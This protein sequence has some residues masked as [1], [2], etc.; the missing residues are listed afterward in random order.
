MDQ[1]VSTTMYSHPTNNYIDDPSIKLSSTDESSPRCVAAVPSMTSNSKPQCFDEEPF[2]CAVIVKQ[3]SGSETT[4]EKTGVNPTDP[5]QSIPLQSPRRIALPKSPSSRSNSKNNPS[6]KQKASSF[7][8][9]R[10]QLTQQRKWKKEYIERT[11]QSKSRGRSTVS[12]DEYS[13]GSRSKNSVP[14]SALGKELLIEHE[15]GLEISIANHLQRTGYKS[16]LIPTVVRYDLPNSSHKSYDQENDYIDDCSTALDTVSSLN[17]S[18]YA[19]D[20][21]LSKCNS[22]ASVSGK[23][24]KAPKVIQHTVHPPL[25]VS[26]VKKKKKMTKKS[27]KSNFFADDMEA[28]S[29][30]SDRQ[31]YEDAQ[32]VSDVNVLNE[33][34]I[35]RKLLGDVSGYTPGNIVNDLDTT[36]LISNTEKP[37]SHQ[38]KEKDINKENDIPYITPKY[39][40]IETRK[41]ALREVSRER[42]IKS[43]MLNSAEQAT[44]NNLPYAG[45]S[46][47]SDNNSPNTLRRRRLQSS[48]FTSDDDN[49][50]NNQNN[51]K[52]FP[53]EELNEFPS[54]PQIDIE[55]SDDT[56]AN[57]QSDAMSIKSTRSAQTYA[58][59]LTC[60]SVEPSSPEEMDRVLKSKQKKLFNIHH[61][62]TCT[63]PK[64]TDPDDES[65]IPC[66]EVH[67]CQALCALVKHVQTCICVN[68]NGNECIIPGC[69]EYKKMWYHYRRCIL[70][71]FTG[72][73]HKKCRLCC[74]MWSRVKIDAKREEEE[75]EEG[76]I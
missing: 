26:S 55:I 63:Y 2:D 72:N 62:L 21:G 71:T 50:S 22:K 42:P 53:Q 3:S 70:R 31:D 47:L 74:N 59:L 66:P 67:Y 38:N 61:A 65:Y 64:A 10:M 45:P 75:I 76:E 34:T 15:E 1:I 32:Q 40:S 69:T 4:V 20:D 35:E 73:Y 24:R 68:G 9:R 30:N 52:G 13:L 17:S 18:H 48:L 12:D 29:E 57:S 23:V 8:L 54:N 14:A 27:G 28:S 60:M 16:S 5:Q 49:K 58:T 36:T 19:S 43:Q 33:S 6:P 11:V 51:D 46:S 41:V 44:N 56:D 25:F 39:S 37:K 7:R